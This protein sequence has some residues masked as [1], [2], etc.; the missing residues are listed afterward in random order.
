MGIWGSEVNLD[1]GDAVPSRQHA[2]PLQ[3]LQRLVDGIPV[4]LGRD[5]DCF[6]TREA[7]TGR[8][9][10]KP[11]SSA[12]STSRKARVIGP[13]LLARLAVPG[14]PGLRVGQDAG[15]GVAVQR[16]GAAG[17]EH[18]PRPIALASLA[19]AYLPAGEPAFAHS[20][21]GPHMFVSTLVIDDPN[22]ADEAS[23]PTFSYQPRP[24]DGS[25]NGF[26]PQA[27]IQVLMI[28]AACRCTCSMRAA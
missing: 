20:F 24:S 2:R 26:F 9:L 19:G 18:L 10:W 14:A 1:A 3:H 21:A 17:A 27:Q 16:D 25:A 4:A 6:V 12:S 5:G 22:V 8:A 7:D 13:F 11:H 28:A 15:L 23:L